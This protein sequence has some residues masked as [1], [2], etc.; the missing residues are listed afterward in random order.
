LG[1]HCVQGCKENQTCCGDIDNVCLVDETSGKVYSNPNLSMVET[2]PP[3]DFG[4]YLQEKLDL[5]SFKREDF[6][7]WFSHSKGG[8]HEVNLIY[9]DSYWKARKQNQNKREDNFSSI[10]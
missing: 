9:N 7:T 8:G 6:I 2:E 3:E 10:V 5:W 1:C 4:K